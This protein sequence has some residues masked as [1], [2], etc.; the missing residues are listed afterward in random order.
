MIYEGLVFSNSKEYRTISIQTIH[1]DHWI[2]KLIDM[3]TVFTQIINGDIPCYKIAESDE[4]FA[5]LDIRPV[6]KGHTLVIPKK[7]VDVLFDLEESD[8]L[9]LMKFAKQ[10]AHAIDA[11]M[12]PV[13]VALT[14]EGLEVPHAHIHLIPMYET[15]GPFRLGHSIE[16][17]S[18]EMKKIADNISN[19]VEL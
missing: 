10:I 2:N 18:E 9:G 1:P 15:G 8:Y 3:A 12:N 6:S 19:E 4:F 11:A 7:E 13:R 5:F 16:C 14:V 17:S